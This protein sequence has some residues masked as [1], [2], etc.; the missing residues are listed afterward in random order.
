M[1][2]VLRDE[3]WELLTPDGSGGF[4]S[5][6]FGKA[7]RVRTLQGGFDLG[8]SEVNAQDS[9][10]GQRDGLA[11]G[12]DT[13]GAPEQQ[14]EFGVVR[15]VDAWEEM[16]AFQAAWRADSM[17]STPGAVSIL[18]YRRAGKTWRVE[19]RPRKFD[20]AMEDNPHPRFQRATAT[21]Q[22]QYPERYLEPMAGQT[23]SLELQLRATSSGGGTSWPIVWPATWGAVQQQRMGDVEV[24]G[25][26]PAPFKAQIFA[27][28]QAGQL[29]GIRISGRGWEVATSRVL[30][31][32]ESVLLD[33]K[34]GTFG[35]GSKSWAGSVTR[36]SD[37]LARLQPGQ[38]PIRFE[39]VDPSNTASV[40]ITWMDTY[41]A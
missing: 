41:P 12:R 17:R 19:G 18:R 39:G 15:D 34:A 35:R 7:A 23:R 11:F 13:F 16:L 28:S 33:T 6:V 21:F 32:G 37:L 30:N 26:R 10:Y 3:Q 1:P 40:V 9:P 22:T 2:A 24:G 20:L 27:P 38:Q 29:S 4:D 8:S 31:A 5:F 14:F 36:R 25:F